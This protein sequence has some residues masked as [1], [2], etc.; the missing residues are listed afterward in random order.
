DIT[1]SKLLHMIMANYN[2]DN[3]IEIPKTVI[4][5]SFCDLGTA[6][7]VFSFF[8]GYEFLLDDEENVF[9]ESEKIF[10]RTC[11]NRLKIKN[12]LINPLNIFLNL[13]ELT[14]II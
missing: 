1:D 3:G 8:G 6:L 7:M 2:W 5:N 10:C 9:S 11:R 14:N 12:F 13:Q 4:A